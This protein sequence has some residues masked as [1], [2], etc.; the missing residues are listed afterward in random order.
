[1]PSIR[2][3]MATFPTTRLHWDWLRSFEAVARHGSLTAAARS[4][5]V[6]QSTVSRHLAFL[7][8][9][10]GSPLWER[11][12]PIVLTERGQVL[13]DA[14]RPMVDA[15]LAA[16]SALDA[17][18]ELRG[19]VTVTTVGEMVRWVLSRSRGGF[20]ERHPQLR[21]RLLSD[22]SV[23]S[24]AAGEA[25]IALRLARPERG[26]LIARKVG[27]EAFDFFAAEDAAL[28]PEVPWLGLSGSLA[29]IAE[30]RF[31]ER[32]F[33]DRPP[34]LLLED[35]EALAFAVQRG[36]GVAV[37]PCRL[38]TRLP[39]LRRV[40]PSDVGAH[41]LG[42]VP[43]RSWWMI[44]HRHQQDV[45]KVRAV[46]DWLASVMAPPALSRRGRCAAEARGYQRSSS[47][48]GR[49]AN[50]P[51]TP[52]LEFWTARGTHHGRAAGLRR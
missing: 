47:V 39:G 52:W 10:S 8:D 31:A 16:R 7:E 35:V 17:A 13:L 50:S 26:D 38:A 12:S 45:P 14:V 9:A 32:A 36:V 37:L 24:L 1:M 43:S 3:R 19:V 33:G 29:N 27:E 2:I 25:D 5:G 23:S 41:D 48:S 11:G 51:G 40:R 49:G 15:A 6:S 28:H 34:R 30:Q 20:Y 44:V 22:N 4:L 46:L 21:L 18:P 42:P